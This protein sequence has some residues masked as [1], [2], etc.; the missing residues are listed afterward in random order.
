MLNHVA[1][2][3]KVTDAGC[4]LTYSER[5]TPEVRWTL[6]LEET[7]PEGQTFKTFIPCHSFGKSAEAIA[8]Q[9]DPGDWVLIADG[10]LKVRQWTNQAGEKE[11]RLEV[12]TWAV[13]VIALSHPAESG[14]PAGN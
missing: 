6:I 4:K 13:Q 1:L 5:G 3:G 9:I 2:L 14:T 11:R 10:K 12:L 8:E 7:G